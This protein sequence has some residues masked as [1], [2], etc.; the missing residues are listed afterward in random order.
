MGKKSKKEKKKNR[1]RV[2]RLRRLYR[3]RARSQ[4]GG[5]W[6]LV[7]AILALG[8]GACFF[9]YLMFNVFGG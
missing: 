5:V 3:F 4:R 7:G 1:K 8:T 9:F 6:A 2:R